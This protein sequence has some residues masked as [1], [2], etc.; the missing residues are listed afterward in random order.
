MITFSQ[1]TKRRAIQEVMVTRLKPITIWN[2]K[3]IEAFELKQSPLPSYTLHKLKKCISDLFTEIK[4]K[5]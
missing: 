4:K 3:H 2:P 5:V 1:I